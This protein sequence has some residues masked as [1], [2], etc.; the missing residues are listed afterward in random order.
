MMFTT[1]NKKKN[2]AN[3]KIVFTQTELQNFENG[4]LIVFK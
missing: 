4:I 3:V 2:Y 1:L